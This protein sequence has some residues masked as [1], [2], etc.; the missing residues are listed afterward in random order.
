VIVRVS[1]SHRDR[2]RVRERLRHLADL[3][4]HGGGRRL[5]G[6]RTGPACVRDRVRGTGTPG[7]GRSRGPTGGGPGAVGA[8][9][10][11]PPRRDRGR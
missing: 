9:D 11:L 3:P 4:G 1:S 2:A 10:G 5:L 6:G 8:P 7:S